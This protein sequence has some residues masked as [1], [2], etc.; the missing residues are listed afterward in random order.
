MKGRK[1]MKYFEKNELRRERK[2]GGKM[3]NGRGVEWTTDGHSYSQRCVLAPKK[4]EKEMENEGNRNQ[5]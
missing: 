2:K 5:D 3:E 4:R 1:M